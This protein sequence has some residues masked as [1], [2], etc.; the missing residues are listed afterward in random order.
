[1]KKIFLLLSLIAFLNFNFLFALQGDELKTVL[2]QTT[3]SL[4]NKIAKTSVSGW[5]PA[6]RVKNFLVDTVWKRI[7][8][9]IIVT[10]WLLLWFIAFYKLKFSDKAEEQSKALNYIIWWTIWVII[11]VSSSFIT[12]K[13]V[14]HEWILI[15]KTWTEQAVNLYEQIIFP[16]LK[17]AMF[18]VVWILFVILLIH[19]FNFIISTSED[20]KKH[21][22]TII[23]WNIIW[24]LVILGATNLVELVY[25]T[26][27]FEKFQI[28]PT[29]LWDIWEGIF[30][31][32]WA[33]SLIHTFINYFVSFV[34]F[35]VLVI[36]IYQAYLLLF[37]P[38]NENNVK[39]LKRNLV[40]IFLGMLFI[41]AWYLI[42][43]FV[44][45]K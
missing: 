20:V 18:I 45:I 16:F 33:I 25:W 38:E 36:I 19:S 44:I 14:S 35:I 30:K 15:S 37:E 13:L 2:E 28:Q 34:A 41:V 22:Q 10:I 32:T 21:S 6:D 40:Y 31:K 11:M 7:M 43:N 24:I 9:P 4:W 23:I 17:L 12:L 29:T 3:T 39:I 5:S 42:T 8:I 26:K 27:T 1:M